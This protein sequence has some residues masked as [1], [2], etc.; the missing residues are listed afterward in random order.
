MAKATRGV[1]SIGS[2]VALRGIGFALAAAAFAA[3][4]GGGDSATDEAPRRQPPPQQQVCTE[5][6]CA[7]GV[8]VRIRGTGPEAKTARVCVEGSCMRWRLRERGLWQVPMARAAARSGA[9]R[10]SVSVHDA[11]GARL[12]SGRIRARVSSSRP[13]GPDCP[14]VRY[15]AGVAFDAERGRLSQFA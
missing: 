3:G 1:G 8:T 5:I 2:V 15:S 4:C 6:G 11:S 9:V 14:P 7:D 12:A 10:V 13:N